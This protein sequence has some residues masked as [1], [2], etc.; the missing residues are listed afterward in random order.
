M[1]ICNAWQHRRLIIISA[2][3]SVKALAPIQLGAPLPTPQMNKPPVFYAIVL[4]DFVGER[5]DELDARSGDPIT[6]VAQ[7]N[8]EWFVAKPIGRLGRPG[9]IPVSFVEIHDPT[10][11]QAIEDV[12]GLMDRGD[13]PRVEDWKRAILNYK[14]NSIALGVIDSPGP[15]ATSFQKESAATFPDD[16][17]ISIQ[18]PSPNG[19][20]REAPRRPPSVGILPDGLLLSA[21]VVSFHFEAD[22]YWFRVNALFQPYTEP[23]QNQ[24]PPAKQL[25]LFRVY[26]D[27]YDF[28]VTLLDTFPQEAGLQPPHPRTLPFMPGPVEDVGDEL[29]A[30]R[31]VDLDD[32]IQELCG[33][34]IT[35]GRYILE[36]IVVRQFLTPKQG[37][38]ENDTVPRVEEIEE[39]FALDEYPDQ[40]DDDTTLENMQGNIGRL[41][42]QDVDRRS[43]GSN[44]DNQY[45]QDSYD[46]HP[47]ARAQESQIPIE[48]SLRQSNYSQSHQR[49]GSSSSVNRRT[50]SG[51]SRSNSPGPGR[52]PSPQQ[53]Q[54][55]TAQPLNMRNSDYRNQQ[56][57]AESHPIDNSNANYSSANSTKSR[58]S[59]QAAPNRSLNPNNA[60]S[61][62][63]S[64]QNPQMAFVKIKIFDRIADDLIAIRVHPRVTLPELMDK[65]QT[66]LGGEVAR[67]KYR[68]SVIDEIVIE[69]DK[70]LTAWIDGTDKH[71]L[72]AD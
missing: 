23:G 65:V 72:F 64:A 28:Q 3:A 58:T 5:D 22:D 32:Y 21:N 45:L 8:R 40:Q 52:Q 61:P 26:K 7:S 53:R 43:N 62:S 35:G 46:R 50:E 63:I 34:S 54:Y 15:N 2:R 27:F 55:Q 67:L 71:V 1:R 16:H 57:W 9:L 44:Y 25:I 13:I 66:R 33:L 4:H 36:S 68:N 60:N 37:D 11:G 47:Y 42:M 14:Q 19:Q 70:Q 31:V 17:D 41:S 48:T 12:T 20:L 18:L 24:L 56:S 69:S 49:N 30:A 39:I 59:S 29:T 38:V 51:Y 6:V 10:T